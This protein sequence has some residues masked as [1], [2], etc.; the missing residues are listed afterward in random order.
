M[1]ELVSATFA[2][3]WPV[4]HPEVPFALEDEAATIGDEFAMLTIIP[5]TAR[6]AT[7]GRPGTRRVRRDVWIQVKL[8]SPAGVGAKRITELGNDVQKI[9]EL[10]S[11]VGPIAGDDPLTIQASTGFKRGGQAGTTDGRWTMALLRFPAWYSDT[12]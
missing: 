4:L 6:Q 9:F 8:W 1:R 5:T 2:T 12:L 11:L 7:Q 10:Q 3:Q